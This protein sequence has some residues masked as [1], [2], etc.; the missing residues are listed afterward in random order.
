[1]RKSLFM[2]SIGLSLLF[3]SAALA[4]FA[5]PE[6]TAEV[7]LKLNSASAG[8]SEKVVKTEFGEIHY[9]EGGQG[10]TI[11]LIH[12][13]YARKEHW[14][15]LARHLTDNYRVIA[16]DL[17]GFGDNEALPDEQ[18]LIGQQQKN[19]SAVFD[20]LDIETAH[21]AA[22]SMGAYVAALL[23][24]EN[25]DRVSSFA[26]IGSPLGIPTPVKSDMDLA[27]ERG[28]KPLLVKS[29]TDFHARMSWL[30]PKPPYVPGPI[31][32]SWMRTEVAVAEK[33]ARIWDVVHT[34]SKA[35]TVLELAPSLT[36]KTLIMWCSSDRI[37]HVSGADELS[38]RLKRPELSILKECGHVPMLDRPDSVAA[39]YLTFLRTTDAAMSN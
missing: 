3:V 2:V 24:N 5:M 30:S 34:M 14:V 26:F 17:P 31:L 13:I 23:A 18:Y 7:L 11:I 32:N 6:R 36:M 1:M 9:L 29:E 27:L 16:L 35:P 28:I 39:V 8:L 37:F 4:W 25:P 21:I 15:D 22:N 20:A 19:L 12:G 10:E 33:N 38:K